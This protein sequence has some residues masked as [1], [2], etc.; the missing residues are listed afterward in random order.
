MRFVLTASERLVSY[1]VGDQD[2]LTSGSANC[3]YVGLSPGQK[4]SMGVTQ[5]TTIVIGLV[6]PCTLTRQSRGAGA[7]QW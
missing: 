7:A 5:W 1:V 6:T 2:F 3:S 4:G